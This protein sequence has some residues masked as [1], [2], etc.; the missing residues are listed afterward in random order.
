MNV[1]L[2]VTNWSSEA[3]SS[4]VQLGLQAS[5]LLDLEGAG[6]VMK[7]HAQKQ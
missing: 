1:H 5:R 7:Q 2:Y 6:G 3:C 4:L